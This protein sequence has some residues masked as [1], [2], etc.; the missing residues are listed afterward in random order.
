M[1]S[2][3]VLV[4]DDE[5]T[6]AERLARNIQEA[7]NG[8]AYVQPEGKDKFD[9]LLRL[10]HERRTEPS[11]STERHEADE[12]DVIVVDYDLRQYSSATTGSRLAYLLRC[13]SGCGFIVIVNQYGTNTF[14]LGLSLG[15]SSGFN[16]IH[17]DFADLHVGDAQIGNPGLWQA[18]FEGYR[19]WYWPIIPEAKDNFKKCVED[20]QEHL[21]ESIIEFL[22]L[23]DVM[24]WI[25]GRAR[26]FLSGRRDIREVTFRSFGESSHSGVDRKDSDMLASELFPRIVAARVITFLN[27]VLLPEQSVIVDAPHL[28]S[29]FPSLIGDK[30]AD[31]DRWNKLCNLS[32]PDDDGLFS[33]NFGKHKFWRPHWLWRPAW[34]WPNIN[35]DEEIEEVKDPWNIHEVDWVF[36]ENISQFVSMNITQEF[37]AYLSPP[38]IKRFVLRD[39]TEDGKS[40]V[41]HLGDQSRL[42]PSTVDY[43]PQAAFGLY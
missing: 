5:I 21:D 43:V 24:D 12:T 15:F 29:R 37:R 19:P 23:T 9:D 30:C 1:S 38:F 36:C 20:V 33:E 40:Y 42:D 6:V 8:E 26:S 32:L 11:S 22:G 28:V 17:F 13:F 7:S 2:F 27:S 41:S 18:D 34:Y 4:Y 3:N 10:L 39:V 31:M 25:P 14:D 16:N 35:R